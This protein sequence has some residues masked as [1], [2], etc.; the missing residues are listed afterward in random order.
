MASIDANIDERIRGALSAE[1][2]AFLQSLEQER[3]VFRQIGDSFHGTMGRWMWLVAIFMIAFTGAG[4]WAITKL[5]AATD[6]RAMIL[7]FGAAAMAWSAV[8]AIKLWMWSRL[9]TLTILRELKRIE[10]RVAAIEAR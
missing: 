6:T 10:V 4:L 5:F 9:H 8:V 7:W 2:Q 3:G 1:D